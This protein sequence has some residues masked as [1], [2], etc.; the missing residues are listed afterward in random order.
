LIW[1]NKR[2]KTA[3]LSFS[4]ESIYLLSEN[5]FIK[6]ILELQFITKRNDLDFLNS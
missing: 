1:K 3:V 4:A 5:I 2:I 6:N